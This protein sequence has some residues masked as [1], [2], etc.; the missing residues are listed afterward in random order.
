MYEGFYDVL[1]NPLQGILKTV[2]IIDIAEVLIIH[3]VIH[4]RLQ[5]LETDLRP[6]LLTLGSV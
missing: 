3:K 6:S 2:H 1:I 5:Q 4:H